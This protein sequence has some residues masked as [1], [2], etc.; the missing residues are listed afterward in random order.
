MKIPYVFKK[1]NNCGRWLVA[2]TDNFHREKSGKYGLRGEC[3]KC[4]NKKSKQH[5]QENRDQILELLAAVEPG[6]DNFSLAAEIYGDYLKN[7]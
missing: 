5:H 6:D 7:A 3:K 1:C 4:K 2:S